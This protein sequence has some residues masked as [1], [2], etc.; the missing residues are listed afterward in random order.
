MEVGI[1]GGGWI[2]EHAYLPLLTASDIVERIHLYDANIERAD[3]LQSKYDLRV[4]ESASDL[5]ASD[6]TSII[7]ATPNNSHSKYT[8]MALDNYKHVLCEKPVAIS[9]ND[10]QESLARLPTTDRILMPAFVNRFR[11]DISYLNHLARGGLIGKIKRVNGKW[12]RRNGIPR[13]GSWITNKSMAGGGVLTDLGPH[14]IDICLS[15]TDGQQFQVIN[16][17]VQYPS[18]SDSF[19]ASWYGSQHS[20]THMRQDVEVSAEFLAKAPD[21]TEIR[22][23][24][25]WASNVSEDYTQF[26]LEGEKGT[27]ELKTLFGFSGNTDMKNIVLTKDNG[28]VYKQWPYLVDYSY[29][30]FQSMLTYFMNVT[31]GIPHGNLTACCGLPVTQIIEEAYRLCGVSNEGLLCF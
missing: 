9:A 19:A 6:V 18:S 5:L 8:N 7:V 30:A 2:I 17:K 15:L 14:I 31:K 29:Q 24:L 4:H 23:E 12:I 27:L 26:V 25:S 11:P 21:S 28:Q 20:M 22:I 1:I 10:Y 3:Y 16:A 13:P